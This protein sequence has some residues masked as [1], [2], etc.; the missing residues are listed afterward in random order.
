[1]K[2]I[3]KI[4][5]VPVKEI[6]IVNNCIERPLFDRQNKNSLDAFKNIDRIESINSH[7]EDFGDVVSFKIKIY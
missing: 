1:M 4:S 7:K 6:L 5:L 2:N 3:Y